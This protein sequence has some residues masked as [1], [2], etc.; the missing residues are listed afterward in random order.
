MLSE[1]LRIFDIEVRNEG[2]QD[3]ADKAMIFR[4]IGDL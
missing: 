1:D 2:R 3:E 4:L